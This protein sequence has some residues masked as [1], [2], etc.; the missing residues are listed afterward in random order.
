MNKIENLLIKNGNQ[1]E[2]SNK[3]II[4]IIIY[5]DVLNRKIFKIIGKNFNYINI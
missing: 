5:S 2:I 3:L 1:K 4:L